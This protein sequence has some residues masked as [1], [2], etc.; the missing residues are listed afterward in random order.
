MTLNAYT[1][2]AEIGQIV[3]ASKAVHKSPAALIGYVSPDGEYSM[4]FSVRKKPSKLVVLPL[5]E[6]IVE[7]YGSFFISMTGLT[8]DA[9]ACRAHCN[10][11]KNS[12][13]FTFGS[14]PSIS[15]FAKSAAKWLTR[16]MYRGQNGDDDDESVVVRPLAVAVLLSGV[17]DDRVRLV[18]VECSGS[19]RDSTF[20]CLGEEAIPGGKDTL[21]KIQEYCTSPLSP[22]SSSPS[23]SAAALSP[24]TEVESVDVYSRF[25]RDAEFITSLLLEAATDTEANGNDSSSSNSGCSSSSSST[26]SSTSRERSNDATAT[27]STDE[28]EAERRGSLLLECAVAFRQGHGPTPASTHLGRFSSIQRLKRIL[29]T[30]AGIDKATDKD[31]GCYCKRGPSHQ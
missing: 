26:S 7:D 15:Y 21:R 29:L 9:S 4:L 17:E 13:M 5:L 18:L 14:A 25:C 3:Y 16:G 22:S 30:G 11:L 23:S 10:L 28:A 27:A 8:A 31:N 24:T 1:D 12:Q 20:V 6:T 2:S 19:V